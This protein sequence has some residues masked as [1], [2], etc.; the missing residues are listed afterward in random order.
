MGPASNPSAAP[1]CQ[2]RQRSEP[3]SRSGT[4]C[5]PSSAVP[6]TNWG[7]NFTLRSR[8]GS[9]TPL[10]GSGS[11]WTAYEPILRCSSSACSPVNGGFAWIVVAQ[12][13]LE[14]AQIEST[15][16]MSPPSSPPPRTASSRR[17]P[18]F[19]HDRSSELTDRDR[20]TAATVREVAAL[21]RASTRTVYMFCDQGRLAHVR[22]ANAIRV[23]S[24]ALAAFVGA[25]RKAPR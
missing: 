11:T 4:T 2:L 16:A 21:L 9:G 6:R 24:S 5:S 1:P 20:R 3:T 8:S 14:I 25:Q 22:V 7:V 17:R 18:R 15:R 12:A 10:F 13:R 23:E 19:E